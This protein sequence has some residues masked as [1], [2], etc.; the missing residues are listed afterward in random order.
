M[1]W[2]GVPAVAIAVF[3]VVLDRRRARRVTDG[4]VQGAARA[5]LSRNERID[6]AAVEAQARSRGA[7]VPPAL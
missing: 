1:I 5:S 2:L 6:L 7:V 4:D 3:A